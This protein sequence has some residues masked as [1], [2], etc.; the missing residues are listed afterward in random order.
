VGEKKLAF[1]SSW[2]IAKDLM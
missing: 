2:A 1:L